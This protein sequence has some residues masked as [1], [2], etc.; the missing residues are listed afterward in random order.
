MPGSLWISAFQILQLKHRFHQN[1]SRDKTQL[2]A[3]YKKHTLSLKT[4]IFKANDRGSY[5]MLK[6]LLKALNLD[7]QISK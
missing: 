6:L 4:H 1:G 3:L 2:Y 7:K 5:T